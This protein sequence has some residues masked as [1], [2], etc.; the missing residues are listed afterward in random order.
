MNTEQ[1]PEEKSPTL[2]YPRPAIPPGFI[3]CGDRPRR[4]AFNVKIDSATMAAL[5][6][7][8]RERAKQ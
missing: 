7:P 8:H 3:A 6:K 2:S 5:L 4:Q 1:K